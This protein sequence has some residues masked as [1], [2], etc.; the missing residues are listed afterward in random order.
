MEWIEVERWL[1][2]TSATEMTMAAFKQER[3]KGVQRPTL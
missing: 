2:C 1:W 3:R